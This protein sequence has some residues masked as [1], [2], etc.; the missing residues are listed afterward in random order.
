MAQAESEGSVNGSTANTV[1]AADFTDETLRTVAEVDGEPL[2]LIY[3]D[4]VSA[5]PEGNFYVLFAPG[6]TTITTMC[7]NGIYWVDVMHEGKH[8]AYDDRTNP[9]ARNVF[10]SAMAMGV[11]AARAARSQRIKMSTLSL[12]ALVAN[13]IHAGDLAKRAND[14]WRSDYREA[15]WLAVRATEQALKAAARI[16]LGNV[17]LR[18][19][20]DGD[21]RAENERLREQVRT[22]KR[23]LTIARHGA[24][25]RNK[26]LAALH[27]V[28]C[29]GGCHGGVG[30]QEE[31]TEELVT[32]AEHHVKRLRRWWTNRTFR[33]AREKAST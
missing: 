26:D 12:E 3:P 8:R 15:N 29:D 9:H 10:W 28:W 16:L 20:P 27:I 31:V 18:A 32:L 6:G 23:E 5:D 19:I 4:A 21:V 11:R 14:E 7:E 2:P 17:R 13:W 33:A 22:L 30:H 24:E 25:R 1:R